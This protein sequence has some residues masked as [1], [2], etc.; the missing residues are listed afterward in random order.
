MHLHN[1]TQHHKNIR[2]PI[3]MALGAVLLPSPCPH[4][5]PLPQPLGIRLSRCV[6]GRCCRDIYRDNG[7]VYIGNETL[8]PW[9]PPIAAWG[10]WL[11]TSRF[12]LCKRR[13]SEELE[14]IYNQFHGRRLSI[15]YP[16]VPLTPRFWGRSSSHSRY[17][18]NSAALR[19][20]KLATWKFII[21]ILP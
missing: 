1:K 3:F 10:Q 20:S 5:S 15:P 14:D 18:M 12:S 17:R 7:S 11:P 19:I 9:E 13:N 21:L 4:A 16:H 2:T 8:N 6:P